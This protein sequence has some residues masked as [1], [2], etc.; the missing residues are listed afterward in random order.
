MSRRG[1]CGGKGD[2]RGRGGGGGP[3]ND[4][5]CPENIGKKDF[6][7]FSKSCCGLRAGLE[8]L[9]SMSFRAADRQ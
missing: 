4:E 3:V 6:F 8:N 2:G 1:G 7:F 9:C 5:T